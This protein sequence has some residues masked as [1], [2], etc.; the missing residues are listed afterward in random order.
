MD[1]QQILETVDD[2]YLIGISNKGIVKR[3]YKE[4]E[5]A[6][7]TEALALDMAA[8]ELTVAVGEEKVSICYPLGESKCSCPSRSICRHVVLGILLAKEYVCA[9]G[10]QEDVL[11][12]KESALSEETCGIPAGGVLEETTNKTLQI[13]GKVEASDKT[14]NSLQAKV[15]EEIKAYP[16]KRLLRILGTKALRQLLE[17]MQAGEEPEIQYSSTITV[18][19][20]G[21]EMVVKLLSPLEYS[22]CSCHKKELCSHKAEAILWCQWKEQILTTE[23]LA[24]EAEQTPEYDREQIQEA[25]RQIKAYLEELFHMG[26]CRTSMEVVNALERLAIVAHNAELPRLESNLR[27][28]AD[29]YARYLRRSA[30]FSVADSMRRIAG[31]YGKTLRLLAAEQNSE[32][33]KLAGEFHA[34]YKPV[35]N[36]DLVGITW[37]HFVSQSGYEGDTIY[38]LEEHTGKWYTYT[39][40]RPT[41]YEGRIRRGNTEK[42]QAPWGLPMPLEGMVGLKLHL[43][44]AKCDEAGRLSSSQDTKAEI[45]DSRELTEELLKGWYYEDFGK[46][47][48]EQIVLENEEEKEPRQQRMEL[49]FLQPTK[50]EPAKFEEVEQVLRMP[51]WDVQGRKVLMEIPYS[52]REEQTIRYLE[53]LKENP[54]PCFLGRLYLK[55]SQL[56]LYP[57]DLFSKKE[58]PWSN[59]EKTTLLDTLADKLESTFK[60]AGGQRQN[61]AG[62]SREGN[63][64]GNGINSPGQENLINSS[65][66]PQDAVLTIIEEAEGALGDLYQVGFDT[67]PESVLQSFREIAERAEAYGME[68]LSKGISELAGQLTMERHRIKKTQEPE[69]DILLRQYIALCDYITI[70]RRKA[71]YDKAG[72]YYLRDE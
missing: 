34:E 25:S 47:F 52:K 48:A 55:E 72:N 5:A 3:A 36:L 66:T 24:G 15:L 37:E 29:L 53:K 71:I 17:R 23:M 35:G 18:K 41:F 63:K 11:S 38:F 31:L 45:T 50:T 44:G 69:S 13:G 4:K 62:T 60:L 27:S 7:G 61:A 20:P 42:A 57:L 32:I 65:I 21:Q 22:S 1:W 51:L 14:E 54:P 67:V 56:Q 28:L 58:L 59:V 43:Q 46:A 19:L 10:K 33:G 2:D 26:L 39:N 49:V 16:I 64:Y 30:S 68:H 8:A 70:A 6:A 9:S 40:A 12:K